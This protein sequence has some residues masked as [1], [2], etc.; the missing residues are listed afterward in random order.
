MHI[1]ENEYLRVEVVPE[2]AEL[3]SLFDKR[4]GRECLWQRDAKY[5]AKSS[6][7]LFPFVGELKNGQYKYQGKSYEMPKHGFARD[8]VFEL[9][10]QQKDS[11]VFVLK[12]DEHTKKI[13]PFEFTLTVRYQLDLGRLSCTYEVWNRGEEEMFFSIGGHPAFQLDLTSR[14]YFSDYYIVFPKDHALTRFFLKKGLLL[15]QSEWQ[16]LEGVRLPLK[17][18]MFYQDAWVLKDLRSAQVSLR[19]RNGSY[20][21][22]FDFKGFSYFGLW[23]PLDAPFICL[24]PWCGVNDSNQHNGVLQNKE[25]IERLE[26]SERWRR[27]WSVAV[28]DSNI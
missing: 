5:W 23:A 7:I 9:L 25:G 22:D 21:L 13:Y 8:C 19:N 2:G 11:L 14:Q 15:P 12:S 26:A 4:I 20:R 28:S 6:P 1:I 18:N 3:R 17:E 16:P 24:E 27:T 10:D